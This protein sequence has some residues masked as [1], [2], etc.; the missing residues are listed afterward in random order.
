MPWLLWHNVHTPWNPNLSIMRLLAA[1]GTLRLPVLFTFRWCDPW[2]GP[3][4]KLPTP[5]LVN[6]GGH[7]SFAS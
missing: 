2:A 5:V 4:P 3:V 1:W 7:R 6:G